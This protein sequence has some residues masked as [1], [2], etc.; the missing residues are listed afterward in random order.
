M[1]K[2]DAASLRADYEASLRMAGIVVPEDRDQAMF[3][4]FAVVREMMDDLRKPWR[5]DEEPAFIQRPVAP[6]GGAR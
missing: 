1:S 2:R 5:Y 6:T 4:A 3:D